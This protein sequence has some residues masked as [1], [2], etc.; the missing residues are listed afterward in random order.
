[1]KAEYHIND[2]IKMNNFKK[3]NKRRERDILIWEKNS[4]DFHIF[5]LY[6]N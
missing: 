6:L 5:Y 1:M 2:K 3:D 4:N